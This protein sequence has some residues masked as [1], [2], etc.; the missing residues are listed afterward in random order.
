LS[1][2]DLAVLIRV[3]DAADAAG[4]KVVVT[5]V[6]L[7]GSRWEV[8]NDKEYDDRLWNDKAYWAQSE[9]FWRDLALAI[10]GHPAVIG[11]N[12]ITE[13]VPEYDTGLDQHSDPDAASEW[14]AEYAGTSHDLPLFYANLITAIRQVDGI[15]PIMVDA[16]WYADAGG[17]EYWPSAL[18]DKKVLYAFHMYEPYKATSLP[19]ATRD[20][21]YRYPG[22]ELRYG[23]RTVVWD[24]AM[25]AKHMA[26][27]F[28]WAHAHGVPNNRVVASEFGCMRQWVDCGTYLRDVLDVLDG[29]QTHWAFYSFREDGWDGMDYELAPEVQSGDFYW[30]IEQGKGDEL[31]RTPH[32]LLDIIEAHVKP[33][34]N[35]R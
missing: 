27:T 23:P 9:A 33:I 6:S 26:R 32:P 11:Y 10:K 30:K 31:K 25:V 8:L 14:Y 2:S 5:S 24:K 28:D 29:Y 12:V 20:P 21:P 1:K 16:G 3:L 13:P 15:T 7:P 22:V 34:P 17:F 4:L 19:N 18:R 35:G